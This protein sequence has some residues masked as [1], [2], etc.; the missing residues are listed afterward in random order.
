MNRRPIFRLYIRDDAPK[1][2]QNI[3]RCAMWD[4]EYK[5]DFHGE[6]ASKSEAVTNMAKEYAKFENRRYH[7]KGVTG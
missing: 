5:T 2:D 1:G 3:W 4:S 7:E 6:G